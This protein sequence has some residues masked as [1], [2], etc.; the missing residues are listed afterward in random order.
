MAPLARAWRAVEDAKN[1]PTLTLS[2]EENASN[3]YCVA[4]R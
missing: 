3:K 1:Y 2:F 4:F